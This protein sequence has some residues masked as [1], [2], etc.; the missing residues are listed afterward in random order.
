MA[1]S[2]EGRVRV[3]GG[4]RAGGGMIFGLVNI[5]DGAAEGRG[6][7]AASRRGWRR[8]RGRSHGLSLSSQPQHARAVAH[9]PHSSAPDRQ[10]AVSARA[11]AAALMLA[12]CASVIWIPHC[13]VLGTHLSLQVAAGGPLLRAQAWH[14]Q[15]WQWPFTSSL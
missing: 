8:R 7:R 10:Q 11:H 13:L 15:R 1:E 5:C 4:V 12:A 6:A 9:T 14:C 2:E 3:G